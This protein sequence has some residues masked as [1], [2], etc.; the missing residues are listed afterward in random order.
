MADQKPYFKGIPQKPVNDGVARVTPQAK[1][2]VIGKVV[3][4][5][6]KQPPKPIAD[7]VVRQTNPAEYR[8]REKARLANVTTNVTVKTPYGDAVIPYKGFKALEPDEQTAL[9]AKMRA[10][11]I[12]NEDAKRKPAE[13]AKPDFNP[14]QTYAPVDVNAETLKNL[15]LLESGA[16]GANPIYSKADQWVQSAQK[17]NESEPNKVV[18]FAKSIGLGLAENALHPVSTFANSTGNLFDPNASFEEFIGAAGNAGIAGTSVL[19]V[20][21][22]AIAAGQVLGKEGAKAAAQAGAKTFAREAIPF[23]ENLFKDAPKVNDLV[24]SS[25]RQDVK[26]GQPS[27]FEEFRKGT[28][29]VEPPPPSAVVPTPET[30][31]TKPTP[32]SPGVTTSAPMVEAKAAKAPQKV[33]G[34]SNNIQLTKVEEGILKESPIGKG[35]TKQE[36]QSKVEDAGRRIDAGEVNPSAVADAIENG[37]ALDTNDLAVVQAGNRR[38]EAVTT[39]LQDQLDAAIAKGDDATIV[40]I[41]KQVD[42][43]RKDHLEY[44]EK[45]QKGKS[46]WSNVGRLMAQGLDVDADTLTGTIANAQRAAGKTIDKLDAPVRE[47]LTKIGTEL[48]TINKQLADLTAENKRLQK[49]IADGKAP[50]FK[51][52]E[53][54]VR[55]EKAI[56]NIRTKWAENKP[57]AR[58]SSDPLMAGR[59]IDELQR[60]AKIAPDVVELAKTYIAEGADTVADILKRIKKDTDV[61]LTEDDFNLVLSGEYR[62]FKSPKVED[63]VNFEDVNKAFAKMVND[64]KLA[65]LRKQARTAPIA[66]RSRIQKSIRKLEVQIKQQQLPNARAKAQIDADTQR[67]IEK[68]ESARVQRDDIYAQLKDKRERE[69][70]PTKT[71]LLELVNAPKSVVLSLDNSAPMTHGAFVLGSHPIT[72]LKATSKS[73]GAFLKEE[74][75]VKALA[76]IRSDPYFDKAVGAGKVK[77]LAMRDLNDAAPYSGIVGRIPILGKPFK[78]SDRAMEVF[79]AKVRLEL[80]KSYAK[81]EESGWLTRFY[82]ANP[83]YAAIGE[84]VN[85]MT[86]RGTGKAAEGAGKLFGT[87]ATAPTYTVSRFKLAMGTPFFNAAIRK[88]PVLAA[89]VLADYTKYVGATVTGLVA[90]QRYGLEVDWD[91]SSSNYLKYKIPGTNVW[92]DPNGGILQPVRLALQMK[93]KDPAIAGGFFLAGKAAPLPRAAMNL[94]AGL[95]GK[96]QFGKSYDPSTPEGKMNLLFQFAPLSGQNIGEIKNEPNLTTE[97]KTVL[98]IISFFGTNVNVKEGTDK[99]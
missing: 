89:R 39:K 69:L 60:L 33:T 38:L 74:N 57:E 29:S 27:S 58:I 59:T 46:E 3:D 61:D 45:V 88:Q 99:K 91:E 98:G 18:Q 25:V 63:A 83:D 40:S 62:Q 7:V 49:L 68:R 52:A 17:S 37:K 67:L 94:Q 85:T 95:R 76:S 66:Q 13:K 28:Q 34:V 86:G 15:Q 8:R 20:A 19:P 96:K 73:I 1:A 26:F 55:R 64:E 6:K 50:G 51:R 71:F 78:A 79:G 4:E 31:P 77:G 87:V 2:K 9:L 32:E 54:Q 14:Y 5:S 36:F 56:T 53:I 12:A 80:F 35:M 82:K 70:H 11:V 92:I 75:R 47:E 24:P 90:A 30:P 44:L 16:M 97:Q 72:W 43:S 84:A 48:E 41:Q 65:D 42:K 81:A 23:G 22:G 21:R 10:E 93:T